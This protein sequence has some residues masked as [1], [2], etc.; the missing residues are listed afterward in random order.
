MGGFSHFFSFPF[1]YLDQGLWL[2]LF[3]V[4]FWGAFCIFQLIGRFFYEMF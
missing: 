4:V 2:G 1:F 3:M